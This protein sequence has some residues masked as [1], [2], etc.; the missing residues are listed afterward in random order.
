MKNEL[1]SN[2]AETKQVDVKYE[3]QVR[4]VLDAKLTPKR[5]AELKQLGVILN[6]DDDYTLLTDL[7]LAQ[8]MS[9]GQKNNTKAFEKLTDDYRQTELSLERGIFDLP[10]TLIA[11]SFVDVYR[12]MKLGYYNEYLFEGGRGSTKSSFIAE[13]VVDFVKNN[14]ETHVVITRPYANTLRDS[15]MAQVTWAINEI[16]DSH[17]WKAT[18]SPMQLVYKPTG[19]TIYFRG[20]DEPEKIK[21]I[22]T[23]FGYIALIWFEEVDQFKGEEQIR[24]IEQ[25]A[26][27][28][29]NIAIK[30]KSYN[31][32]KTKHHWI[33]KYKLQARPNMLLHKSTYKDVPVEWL[34]QP[35]VDEALLLKELNPTAYEH[36]YLGEMVG[37][38]YNVF[39][40]IVAQEISD[41]EIENY[42]YV[43][44]GQD[45]GFFPDPN[46]LA[47][48][49]YD[50]NLKTLYI[51]RE[52][53]GLR[54]SS[55]MWFDKI[56]YLLD[57]NLLIV[58]DNNERKSINDMRSYGLNMVEAKKGPNSLHEGMKW[59][60]GLNKIIID[61][62][63][64]PETY[65]EFLNYEYLKDK[66][67]NAI[68]AYSDTNDH[69]IAAV[70]YAMEIVWKKRGL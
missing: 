59:L 22:K 43:Y 14:P 66:E 1:E 48:M 49:S 54:Q 9:A 24:N 29:G 26:L 67:G 46:H 36:E 27:R 38:G 18:T 70:R 52:E 58:A 16:G 28:G 3:D 12:W 61:P 2:F 30:I 15:V 7:I 69:A 47:G 39:E 63:R 65:K 34:G 25:S 23:P 68:T 44:H 35:F 50:A 45:W 8:A 10:A 17:N 4:A 42:E 62:V 5:I 32:P 41:I 53:R 51:F 6:S 40:N 57:D 13:Y 19:Q 56:S 31:T 33:N 11:R 64:C 21:S 37:Q 60:A 20:G 55:E